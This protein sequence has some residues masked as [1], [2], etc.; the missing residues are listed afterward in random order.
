MRTL[1]SIPCAT[2]ASSR[3][4]WNYCILEP[5]KKKS[6]KKP[7]TRSWDGSHA[8]QQAN[9]PSQIKITG[10][11]GDG[12]CLCLVRSTP[13]RTPIGGSAQMSGHQSTCGNSRNW[14]F[15]C[16]CLWNRA[17]RPLVVLLLFEQAPSCQLVVSCQGQLIITSRCRCFRLSSILGPRAKIN[18]DFKTV[19]HCQR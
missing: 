12:S 14:L 7:T 5:Q 18:K 10:W 13:D 9:F 8:Q 1:P 6:K 3:I 15:W 19:V 4:I 11:V 16:S 17:A 2:L